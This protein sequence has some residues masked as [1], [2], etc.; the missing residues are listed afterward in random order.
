MF[1][2]AEKIREIT[3]IVEAKDSDNLVTVQAFKEMMQFE[4]ILYATT[5]FTDTYIDGFGITDRQASGDIFTF[6]D[7]CQ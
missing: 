3:L 4:E 6:E 5:E 2:S 1:P 7:I